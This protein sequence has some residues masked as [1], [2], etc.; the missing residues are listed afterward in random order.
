MNRREFLVRLGG[1]SL[2][3]V[4]PE[5]LA[6]CG[7]GDLTITSDADANGHTHTITITSA[8]ITGGAAYNGNTSQYSD[9]HYH[10]VAVNASQLATVNAGGTVQ[11]S[12]SSTTGGSSHTHT[13]TIHK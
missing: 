2:L 9:G 13:F 6:G 3:V 11:V 12:T 8:Q 4:L 7:S 10:V 5:V 1:M